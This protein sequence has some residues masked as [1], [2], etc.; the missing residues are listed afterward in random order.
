MNCQ[1][2]RPDRLPRD[3]AQA[4]ASARKLASSN[5][6]AVMAGI[7]A[8]HLEIIVLAAIVE[9]DPQPEAVRQRELLLDRLAG[10]DGGRALVV[11]HL[12]RHQMPPVR[13]RVEQH[14]G[15]PALD[16]AFEHG[17]E[18]FVGGVERL[19]GEVV[20]EQNEARAPAPRADAQ[21]DAAATAM[22][23]RWISTSLSPATSPCTALTSELLPMPRA[24]QSSALLAGSPR[25]KRVV[26]AS[27]VSR[28]RSMPLSSDERHAVDGFDRAGSL[29][30]RPA[31]QRRRPPRSRAARARA[32]Q[33]A[34]WP[35]QSARKGRKG[36]PES[37]CRGRCKGASRQ[38]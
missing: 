25:A 35:G 29:A 5:A 38:L 7:A 13:G 30:S 28:A 17:L 31:R 11:D 8:H 34:R 22:S 15:G 18:R 1:A 36:V 10:I 9:A 4:S 12:A 23:S 27:S 21:A 33:A 24:P 3:S 20:A 19:E 6:Q 37:S 16:A 14:I 32:D 2:T 26:L